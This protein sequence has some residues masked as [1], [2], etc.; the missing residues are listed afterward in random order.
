MLPKDGRLARAEQPTQQA[1]NEG[2]CSQITS[3]VAARAMSARCLQL[4]VCERISA[5]I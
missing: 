5:T 3:H 4:L 1:K 2:Y